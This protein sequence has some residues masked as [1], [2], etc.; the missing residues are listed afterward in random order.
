MGIHVTSNGIELAVNENL[1]A[2]RTASGKTYGWHHLAIDALVLGGSLAYAN[3]ETYVNGTNYYMNHALPLS[4]FYGVYGLSMAVSLL[5]TYYRFEFMYDLQRGEA[6]HTTYLGR[7]VL[8]DRTCSFSG[9]IHTQL[10]GPVKD[11]PH[12]QRGIIADLLLTETKPGIVMSSLPGALW[13]VALQFGDWQAMGTVIEDLV[14]HAIIQD[15][16]DF[17]RKR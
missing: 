8:R 9:F 1:F 3:Y 16:A 12:R 7:Y 2:V 17:W 5:Y 11:R 6:H 10:E 14:R 4:V 15:K 13:P